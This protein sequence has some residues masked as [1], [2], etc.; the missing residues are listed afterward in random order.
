MKKIIST[1]LE[2]LFVLP[3][4]QVFSIQTPNAPATVKTISY[5]FV[6]NQTKAS[7]DQL[8]DAIIIPDYQSHHMSLLGIYFATAQKSQKSQRPVDIIVTS[9]KMKEN[10]LTYLRESYRPEI[11]KTL[12]K[13]TLTK[14]EKIF[15]KKEYNFF[16]QFETNSSQMVK[17]KVLKK[18]ETLSEYKTTYL[19]GTKFKID[20]K[21]ISAKD[22]HPVQLSIPEEKVS[23]LKAFKP[24]FGVI[25]L[26]NTSG[27]YPDAP[28]VSLI[29]RYKNKNKKNKSLWIDC[30]PQ[31]K[32][33]AQKAGES[34]KKVNVIITHGHED[35]DG[36]IWDLIADPACQKINL[37]SHEIYKAIFWKKAESLNL[38]NE[39]LDKVKFIDIS[40]SN[41]SHKTP[42]S[43]QGISIDTL[44]AVHGMPTISL[45]IKKQDG[46]TMIYTADTANSE[47]RLKFLLKSNV[48]QEERAREIR[49]F[50]SVDKA[51]IFIEEMG[52]KLENGKWMGGQNH[53]GTLDTPKPKEIKNHRV[54]HWNKANK[55]S[56]PDTIRSQAFEMIEAD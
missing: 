3:Q 54:V 56:I 35:H 44:W 20:N 6:P 27:T 41:K 12:D 13:T 11:M 42:L 19:G 7:I 47:E 9:E 52:A 26:G 43:K 25:I 53:N 32:E 29:L 55:N 36:G 14:E 46:T 40:P 30:G 23:E 51:D 1:P 28:T 50:F 37:F 22:I 24:N 31:I 34:I 18:G 17:I 5:G 38:K 2:S 45:K 49:D 4:N 10:I 15:L 48:I 33:L 16:D 8:P 21:V 39:A